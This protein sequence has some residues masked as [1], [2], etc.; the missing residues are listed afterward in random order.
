[1]APRRAASAAGRKPPTR[2][3]EDNL[4]WAAWLYY[5]EGLTQAEIAEHMGVSRPS[6]NAYLA[7]ARTRGIV[8]IEIAPERFR[9]LT[10]ARAMQDHFGL[11]DCYVIPSEGGERSLIDRLGAA[12]AQV[13]ARVTRSGDTLAVTWGRT[14][15][16][17]A[18][19]VMP[20]GLKDVRVIQATGG[21]TAKIPWTPEACATRLAENLGARCIPLSAPAIVSAPEMRDLLLREPVLAE[22]IEALGQADRI[23]LGISSLRPE[24]TIH[25]SGFFDGISLHDHYHSAV[26]SIT[27]RMIDANGAK[28]EGPLEERTIGIDLDQIRRVPERL[29]VAGGLDKVQAILAALRG[30]YVTVLV[31][32]ADTARAILTS[33][34][35]ED[36]PRRRSPRRP[37][38]CAGHAVSGSHGARLRQAPATPHAPEGRP[39]SP[40]PPHRAGD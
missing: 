9:A 26:G 37:C 35:Y 29:A 15:L 19:N 7:D 21:T 34:G 31:T 11:S 4:L 23:V 6:V 13:L 32:D 25:T 24:S 5:E 14:T 10:L 38:P 36:R 28:V 17:L 33:E 18:N 22:Q 2:F 8:S 39:R 16:A 12:A 20:A 27:G 1:M 3:G 30:G 40:R